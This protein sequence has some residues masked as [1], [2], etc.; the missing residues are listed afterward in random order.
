MTTPKEKFEAKFEVENSGCWNWMACKTPSGYGQLYFD[1]RWQYAHRVAYQMY[2]GE[3][4]DGL[5]VCH[6][7]DNPACVNPAHLFPGTQADNMHDCNN[8]GRHKSNLPDSSGKNNCNSKLTEENV[9]T[10]HTLY[11][12]GARQVNLAKS[13][14]VSRSTICKIVHYLTWTKI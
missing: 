4:P 12:N 9:R 11:A 1:G 6:K 5:C 3:I 7:C 10:I 14:G 13:F 8:K 2:V